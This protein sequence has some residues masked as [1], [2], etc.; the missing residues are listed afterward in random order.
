MR[1]KSLAGDVEETPAGPEDE[2]EA[3]GS[4]TLE[5]DGSPSVSE[6]SAEPA[7]EDSDETVVESV[8]ETTAA[9]ETA[10]AVDPT[11]AGY[12]EAVESRGPFTAEPEILAQYSADPVALTE[13]EPFTEDEILLQEAG[14]DLRPDTIVPAPDIS[15]S[16]EAT[17]ERLSE[18]IDDETLADEFAKDAD[19]E[20]KGS[21]DE[22]E[23]SAPAVT[24]D[25]ASGE[26]N[27]EEKQDAS[28]DA[29][30]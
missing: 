23:N 9:E 2:G 30:N 15:A 27:D 10:S 13:A 7:I 25:A 22:T 12:D 6:G 1:D 26:S 5:A 20:G 11:E 16:E 21:G 24:E 28:P 4:P 3:E 8:E 18:I 29:A 17:I 19:A 14:R